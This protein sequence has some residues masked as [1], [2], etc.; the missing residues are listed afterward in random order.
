[1]NR[2]SLKYS[3][4]LTIFVLEAIMVTLVLWKTQTSSYNAVYSMHKEEE[5][6]ILN[7]IDDLVRRALLTSEYGQMQNNFDMISHDTHINTI[8][9][10][11]ANDR[12]VASNDIEL[13]GTKYSPLE[14]DKDAYWRSRT[15]S[16]ATGDLGSIHVEFSTALTKEA[17]RNA[18]VLGITIAGVSMAVIAVV[19]VLIGHYLVRRLDRLTKAAQKM[20]NGDLSATVDTSGS[21]EVACLS[22]TFDNMARKIES[23]LNALS[24][25]KEELI[26]HKGNLETLVVVRTKELAAAN[27]ALRDEIK[28]RVGMEEEVLRSQ[29]LEAVGILAGGIAHDFNNLLTAVLNNIYLARISVDPEDKAFKRMET[30]E[31]VLESAKAL[32][33]QLLTFSKG[34]EPVKES[35]NVETMIKETASFALRGSNVKFRYYMDDNLHPVEVD[36]G[37]V[38]QVINNLVINADQAMPEGG[39][40]NVRAENVLID[41]EDGLPLNKGRYVKLSFEDEGHGI[42]E[43]HILKVFD[44]YFTTKHKGSGLGLASSYSVIRSHGGHIS[45]ESELGVGT[46]FCVYLPATDKQP[47]DI[48]DIKDMKTQEPVEGGRVL[49]MEDEMMIAESVS[50]GLEVFGFE[51]EIAIEGNE[52]IDLYLNAKE[53]GTPF[54]AVVLDLTVK[55]GMGGKETIKRLVEINPDVKAIVASG[56]SKDPLM[57]RFRDFGFSGVFTKPYSIEDLADFLRNM[58]SG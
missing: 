46:A 34:G 56:Y 7:I 5:E 17:Y 53:S 32:T 35:K 31:K 49:L 3:I 47:E 40:M 42:P 15:F 52:A 43:E 57:S 45:V 12:I 24:V 58:I 6:V 4:A 37:Q 22:R 23:V 55:G 30:A 10:T 39:V 44:P 11:D 51:T 54:D 19:G 16:T 41:E 21:D 26:E 9:L 2:I 18:V 36:T 1:M 27:E 14:L 25:K 48:E 50:A 13:L 8:I 28:K 38:S 20:A 29:K 33:Q